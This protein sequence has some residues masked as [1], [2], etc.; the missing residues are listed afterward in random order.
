MTDQA[1]LAAALSD[2]YRVERELGAG[3][4]ATVYLAE[5]LKH[6]RPVA[7]KVLRPEL[8]DA[9]GP[10]RFLR[11]IEIA[12]RLQ[13]PH[14]LPVHDSGEAD[15]L[16]YYVMPFVEGE[17]LGARLARDGALAVPDAVRILAEVADAL[18]YAHQRGLVH[19]DIKPDNILLSGQHA[20]VADFG[21][22]RAA[23]DAGGDRLTQTGMALGTPAYMAPEQAAGEAVDHRADIYALGIVA[24]QALAGELPFRG[25]SAQRMVAAHL[26]EAPDPITKFRSSLPP[27]LAAVVMR[28]LEKHPADRIQ[29]AAE[30]QQQLLSS[31]TPTLG[32]LP[33]VPAEV[34]APPGTGKVVALFALA[35]LAVLAIT[36]GLMIGLGLPSW[37]FPAAAGL[38]AVGLPIL[39]TTA[40][41]ERRRHRGITGHGP[42]GLFT[43]KRAIAGGGVALGALGIGVAVYMAMRVLG[44]GPV[45]TLVASGVLEDHPRVI[46]ADFTVASGDSTLAA[47]VTEAFRVDLGQS[48]SLTLVQAGALDEAFGRMQRERPATLS[49]E[50]AREVAVREGIRAVITGEINVVGGAWVVS[51]Q[52]VGA[53]S[54]EVL[55]PARETASDSTGIIQAVDRLSKRIRERIGESLRTIRETPG[56]E[57]VTTA[58][59][60]ALRK[61][62]QGRR[63]G[64]AGEPA[65]AAQLYQE[66][67]ALDTSFAAAHRGLAVVYG[68]MSINRAEAA[69]ANA[70]AFR[71]RDRL[72]ELE[73][74]WA[75]GQYYQSVEDY[76]RAR[77][78]YLALLEREPENYRAL[79]NLGIVHLRQR[80]DEKALEYYQRSYDLRPEN[81]SAAFNLVTTNVNVGRL[82]RARA[83]RAQFTERRPGHLFN[84][85][86]AYTVAVGERQFDSL[87]IL[88]DSLAARRDPA[89]DAIVESG[90]VSVAA[91][92]G[93]PAGIERALRE[94]AERA[95]RGREVAEHLA[96]V[97][98]A[99]T[100]DAVV[101]G[102][103]A[104]GLRRVEQAL[105][106]FPLAGLEPLDRPYGELAEFYARVGRPERARQLLGEFDR[107]VPPILHAQ[108][109]QEIG[110][111]RGYAL[112]A[113]N[114]PAEALQEFTLA[115]RGMCRVCLVPA[116][117][118]AWGALGQEDSVR[119][120]LE[121]LIETPDDDRLLVEWLELPGAYARLGEM[122][123]ARGDRE[124][125]LRYNGK[126]LELWK[127]ADPEFAPVVNRV[128]ERQ[129]Q[130]TAERP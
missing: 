50:L 32:T 66:A 89:T 93:Q 85:W 40:R 47:A 75:E 126:F 52:V 70:A 102:K 112:L 97:V 108:V 92:L 118:E 80:Q 2:R 57:Q 129:R 24:Y 3:G 111:A 58:S 95:R 125:A 130:L 61:Y 81:P 22:A 62:S 69:E 67:I 9:I 45:G 42:F 86:N 88:V 49:A 23:Q 56:L 44:I 31:I 100:Y 68:N 11:E 7:I 79:N 99:G 63:A 72:P 48:N 27:A 91:V 10:G 94:G 120:T 71:H 4:M 15:G 105:A 35:S 116:M 13:H 82:D 21:I 6:H 41:F 39:V 109:Q 19:R 87:A 16:L 104:E 123:E 20:L 65:L 38:M 12:A 128:K 107:E 115:D 122:Y 30:L 29:S 55:V 106:T 113:E 98:R 37:V 43:W 8:A 103:P 101:R 96:E 36:Y 74:L 84:L 110:R 28:C 5:D 59:L 51:A 76:D 25:Q 121:R 34:A 17:S 127:N 64:D 26:S 77:S 114:R 83:V 124:K 53:E 60:P 46:L 54:G 119:V 1:R 90:R 18:A 78:A 117:A 14:I 73:R 33:A